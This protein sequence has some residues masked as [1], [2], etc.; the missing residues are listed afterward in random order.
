MPP[1]PLKHAKLIYRLHLDDVAMEGKCGKLRG[2][3]AIMATIIDQNL[4][5]I[6]EYVKML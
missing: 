1:F 2:Y 4:T 5:G 6:G 3:H